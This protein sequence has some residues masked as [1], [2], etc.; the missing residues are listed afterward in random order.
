MAKQQQAQT[1]IKDAEAIQQAE[2]QLAAANTNCGEHADQ[3]RDGDPG[4]GAEPANAQ[5]EA[6]A[7]IAAA[8]AGTVSQFAKDMALLTPAGRALV[9]ELL[10]MKSAWTGAAEHGPTAILPGVTTFL[11]GVKAMMP[12]INTA[13]GQFGKQISDGFT[14]IG[15][16]M[17]TSQVQQIF[18]GLVANGL[19]FNQTVIPAIA[20]IATAL[21]KVGSQ[22]GAVT[23]I[24]NLIAGLA[25]G[26]T[27]M[28]TALGQFIP[29]LNTFLSTVGVLFEAAGNP[30]GPSSG[31]WRPDSR[32]CS[33]PCSRSSSSWGRS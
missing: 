5:K 21:A 23:G 26:L 7:Q 4:G 33:R 25:K 10:S 18:Q 31:S 27:A 32:P 30:S 1:Q 24:S 22:S 3:R 13:V 6:A 28:V 8:Q 14:A 12:E 16:A 9:N 11:Q 20:G 19:E 29:G 2:P 17:K 15:N